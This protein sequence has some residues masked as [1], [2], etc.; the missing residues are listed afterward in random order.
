[1]MKKKHEIPEEWAS[2]SREE[3]K[4]ILPW[5]CAFSLLFFLLT[6]GVIY[7][8]DNTGITLNQTIPLI[9]GDG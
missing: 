2:A 6:Y 4:E 9:G 1:M 5:L 8:I 7:L 3:T